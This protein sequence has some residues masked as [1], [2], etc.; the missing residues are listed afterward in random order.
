ML[1][2][3]SS[4]QQSYYL[5]IKGLDKDYTPKVYSIDSAEVDLETKS[6]LK[7]LRS[8]GYWLSEFQ[9]S[10]I[11]QDT[12]YISFYQGRKFEKV[13]VKYISDLDDEHGDYSQSNDISLPSDLIGLNSYVEEILAEFENNGYPFAKIETDS[14]AIVEDELY[15]NMTIDPGILITFDSIQISPNGILNEKFISTYLDLKNGDAYSE[16]SISNIP[17]Q[18]ENLPFVKL[19]D[20]AISY[21]LKQAK[22]SLDLEK[23]PVNYFNGILGMVPN[24]VDGGVEFTG[25][26]NLSLKNLF[27][28]A[29]EL[30][31]H[32]EKLMPET[33]KLNASYRHPL[34]F[35]SPLDLYFA[36]DQL[37]QDT[38][39]SNRSIHVAFEYRPKPELKMRVRYENKLGNQLNMELSEGGDFSIDY[40]GL[41]FEYIS[42]DNRLNPKTGFSAE[43]DA[44]TGRK[45]IT[46]LDGP[47]N[48]TQYDLSSSLRF[49]QSL[50]S[51]SVLHLETSG[52]ILLNDYLFL[53]DLYRIGGLQSIRGFD[54]GEFYASKYVFSRLEW[55]FLLDEKSFLLAFYDQ[56]F[57][58]YDLASTDVNDKPAGI[59]VGMQMPIKSGNFQI[60]YGL[61]RREGESFSFDSS[62]IHFGYKALF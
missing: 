2:L 58:N 9:E 7:E 53:N 51:K 52:G 54:E 27:K 61:G 18:M 13:N 59:G 35:D 12:L 28:S 42:F 40:Y 26:L 5:N 11:S 16:E 45:D 17:R 41:G 47:P 20:L 60:I 48:S 34:I 36:Y 32:W 33:Q 55:R 22:V 56:G 44:V 15:L 19:K 43:L 6:K 31:I 4:A 38:A 10:W 46:S 29:K 3:V 1:P 30:E 24:Q 25:E 57:L 14:A 39:F 62:K 21:E 37:K 23:V 8:Y 50:G 49:Y